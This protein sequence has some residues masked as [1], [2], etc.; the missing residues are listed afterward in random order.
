MRVAAYSY[1]M[2]VETRLDSL[3]IEVRMRTNAYSDWS[4]IETDL[5]RL[6]NKLCKTACVMYATCRRHGN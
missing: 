5:K 6:L 4:M 3:W 1:W 2:M